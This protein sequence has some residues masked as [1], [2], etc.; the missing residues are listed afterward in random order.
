MWKSLLMR[1]TFGISPRD[2]RRE[3]VISFRPIRASGMFIVCCSA[4]KDIATI[5]DTDE[6]GGLNVVQVS[7]EFSTID[8]DKWEKLSEETSG[9]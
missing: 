7:G 2:L 4:M 1:G 3:V 5:S 8:Q 6:L 9:G